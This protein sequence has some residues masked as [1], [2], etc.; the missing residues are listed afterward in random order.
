MNWFTK[1]TKNLNIMQ[2]R[3][4]KFRQIENEML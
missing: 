3:I 2:G 4:N 1:H